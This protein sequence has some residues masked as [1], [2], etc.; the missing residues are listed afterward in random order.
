MECQKAANKTYANKA[1]SYKKILEL[2]ESLK[3]VEDFTIV[4]K[5][6]QELYYTGR[7]TKS[8]KDIPIRFS[9]VLALRESKTRVSATVFNIHTGKTME[10]KVGMRVYRNVPFKEGDIIEILEGEKKPKSQKVGGEWVKSTTETDFWVKQMSFI[11][12]S[13]MKK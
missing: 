12:K 3:D 5:L 1:K 10:I 11:R 4:E 13:K 7:V 9:F 6:E 2:Q 8:S